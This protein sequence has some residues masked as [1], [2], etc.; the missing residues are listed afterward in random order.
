MLR[1]TSRLHV[2]CKKNLFQEMAI[3][4]QF[5]LIPPY[6]SGSALMIFFSFAV[7]KGLRSRSDSCS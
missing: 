7:W 4:A 2:F 6:K 1:V 5:G 3:W